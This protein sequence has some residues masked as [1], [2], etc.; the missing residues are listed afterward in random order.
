M[1]EFWIPEGA[2][3]ANAVTTLDQTRAVSAAPSGTSTTP[4]APNRLGNGSQQPPDRNPELT[5]SIRALPCSTTPRG[6]AT[7]A[8]QATM[9]FWVSRSPSSR[10][11][12][13][14]SLSG[15]KKRSSSPRFGPYQRVALSIEAVSH[16]HGWS[17]TRVDAQYR[18][19]VLPDA[20]RRSLSWV[21]SAS[22][23]T[24]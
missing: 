9:E 12:M 16:F 11:V 4:V 13:N 23:R 21:P 8:A 15:L 17:S 6:R 7:R 20:S 2:R 14:D 5:A 24:T 18:F 19:C 3:Y 22:T 1:I 10:L